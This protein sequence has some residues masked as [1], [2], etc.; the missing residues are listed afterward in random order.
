MEV[1]KVTVFPS[2]IQVSVNEAMHHPCILFCYSSNKCLPF[3]NLFC[4]QISYQWQKLLIGN[5]SKSQLLK[6]QMENVLPA[7]IFK[8]HLFKTT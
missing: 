4:V 6:Q 7:H 3:F 8:Q 5:Q 2:A 1:D